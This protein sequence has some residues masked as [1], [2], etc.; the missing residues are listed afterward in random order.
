[1]IKQILIFILVIVSAI[2][3]RAQELN[4]QVQVLAPALQSNSANTDIINSLQQ[5]VFEFMNNTKWTGDK[6]TIEERIDCSILITINELNNDE[7]KGTIQAQAFR[8]AFNSSYRTQTFNYLDKDFTFRYLRNTAVIFN[9]TRHADNLADVLAFYAYMILGSD[10]DTFSLQGGT[11]YYEKAQQIVVNAQGGAEPGWKSNEDIRNRYWLIDNALQAMFE[12]I[13]KFMYEY[14]RLGMDKLYDDKDEA[15]KKMLASL[16]YLKQI[17]K[18]RPGSFALQVLFLSKSTEFIS[19]FK[20]AY[21]DQK[22][23]AYNI[24][25]EVDGVN[26]NKYQQ[27]IR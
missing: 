8:P 13:R 16:D 1:M 17:H 25:R 26:A 2:F 12:P 20:E 27:I 22:A 19:V 11:D 10:Y 7:F 6:F 15:I 24:L 14:H 5:S 9:P 23:A 4:C 21:P 3:V 18:T